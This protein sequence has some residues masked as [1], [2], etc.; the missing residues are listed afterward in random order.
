M[1]R[2]IWQKDAKLGAAKTIAAIWKLQ[3]ILLAR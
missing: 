3:N 1:K 2:R